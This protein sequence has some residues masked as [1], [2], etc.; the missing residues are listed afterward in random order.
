[1]L[2]STLKIL[3]AADFEPGQAAAIAAAISGEIHASQY[4]TVPILD[5]RIRGID[6][7]FRGID[8]KF[9][10]IDEKFRGIDEKFRG[11]DDKFKGI[12]EKFKAIDEKFKAIDE[13]FKGIDDK[14]RVV[15]NRFVEVKL[16]IAQLEARLTVRM[17]TFGIAAVGVVVSTT[18]FIVQHFR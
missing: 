7:K 10:G 5:D 17:M 11:I 16:E 1:M 6:E 8:E 13:K 2:A 18:F 4:V 9:R 12:D 15:D 3:E 14:F